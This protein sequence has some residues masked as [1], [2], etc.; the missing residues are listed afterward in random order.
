MNQ[1]C[2]ACQEPLTEENKLVVT[3]KDES[4]TWNVH[5]SPCFDGLTRMLAAIYGRCVAHLP[6]VEDGTAVVEI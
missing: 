2:Y 4:R 6:A 5:R 1:N 3:S